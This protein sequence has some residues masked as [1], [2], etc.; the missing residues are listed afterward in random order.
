MPSGKLGVWLN[1]PA[2]ERY[3][4]STVFAFKDCHIVHSIGL[5]LPRV[6]LRA[7]RSKQ[8]PITDRLYRLRRFISSP[9]CEPLFVVFQPQY[10]YVGLVANHLH[11]VYVSC[12]QH[13]PTVHHSSEYIYIFF[14]VFIYAVKNTKRSEPSLSV[15]L[16]SLSV[17]KR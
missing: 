16:Y 13:G 11:V 9:P 1:S 10:R 17:I 8:R 14:L 15:K 4:Y 6:L 5:H 7:I 12:L 3:V 2:V